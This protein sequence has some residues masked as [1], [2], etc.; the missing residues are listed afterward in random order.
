[1]SGEVVV[2][3]VVVIG[4]FVKVSSLAGVVVGDLLVIV[5][6]AV[7]GSVD[8]VVAAVCHET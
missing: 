3:S 4:D 6:V 8:V 2:F 1:M 5:E 7:V